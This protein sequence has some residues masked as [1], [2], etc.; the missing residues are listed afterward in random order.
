M[1]CPLDLDSMEGRYL[2]IF[3]G[4]VPGVYQKLG[5]KYLVEE[6]DQP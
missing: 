1:E 6:H 5:T 2:H 4:S 3:G